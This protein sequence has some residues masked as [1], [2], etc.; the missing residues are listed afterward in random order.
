MLTVAIGSSAGTGKVFAAAR[1]GKSAAATRAMRRERVTT[2]VS[3]R[4][5]LA[6]GAA[7]QYLAKPRR[8]SR[9]GW[10]L[11]EHG[12]CAMVMGLSREPEM[13]RLDQ[14]GIVA[15]KADAAAFRQGLKTHA[16][17]VGA[18]RQSCKA[19]HVGAVDLRRVG[20][21]ATRKCGGLFFEMA[22]NQSD[23]PL[24]VIAGHHVL[25]SSVSGRRKNMQAAGKIERHHIGAE[26][27]AMVMHVHFFAGG[28]KGSC[29]DPER[30]QHNAGSPGAGFEFHEKSRHCDHSPAINR[31]NPRSRSSFKSSIS[32]RPTEKRKH[33]P[34]G[35]QRVAVRYFVQSN[36]MTRLSKPPQE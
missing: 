7:T 9:R 20:I 18:G 5:T 29:R 16:H 23:L 25:Q 11:S 8:E 12:V 19:R 15:F 34:P 4:R 30:D 35:A 27:R 17:A 24:I 26:V 21:I 13:K 14:G 33:G 6:A 28:C 36:G 32:S 22:A 31:R 1:L 10:L 2:A 3:W